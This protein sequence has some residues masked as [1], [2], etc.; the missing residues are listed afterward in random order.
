MAK[1][2]QQDSVQSACSSVT[3]VADGSWLRRTSI[4]WEWCLRFALDGMH[5]SNG[6][7]VLDP[8]PQLLELFVNENWV[9]AD[10]LIDRF[11]Q[12]T[13][14]DRGVV[15]NVF[16]ITVHACESAIWSRYFRK[17]RSGEAHSGVA[18]CVVDVGVHGEQGPFSFGGGAAAA[19]AST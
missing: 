13:T 8:E 1:F 11:V 14:I 15:S 7:G 16:A 9:S 17:L 2:W 10:M 5:V 19:G 4:E 6:L 3:Q 18:R 12:G